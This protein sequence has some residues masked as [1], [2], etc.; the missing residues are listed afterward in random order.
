[1]QDEK[2]WLHIAQGNPSAHTSIILVTG[3]NQDGA[4]FLTDSA[5]GLHSHEGANCISH[6]A[7]L[8]KSSKQGVCFS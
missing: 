2:F 1:M 7:G 8:D 6:M 4:S 5:G 3:A